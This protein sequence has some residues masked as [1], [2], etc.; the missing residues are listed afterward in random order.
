[1]ADKSGIFDNSAAATQRLITSGF[2]TQVFSKATT[3]GDP[4]YSLDTNDTNDYFHLQ[5]TQRSSLILTLNGLTGNADL[6][7]LDNDGNSMQGSSNGSALAESIISGS[8]L[9]AGDYYIRVY[10]SNGSTVV[11]QYTLSVSTLSTSRTDLLWRN[12]STGQN[13]IWLMNGTSIGTSAATTSVRDSNWKLEATGDMDGDTA[14]D[15]I[16]RNYATGQNAIWLMDGTTYRSA[17]SFTSVTNT[18]FKIVGATDFDGDGKTDIVWRNNATG[19]NLIWLMNGLTYRTAVSLQDF[20]NANYRIDA[21]GD[22]NQDGKV[23]LLW[24]NYSTGQNALWVMNG[25]SL[26]YSVSLPTLATSW[27]LAGAADLTNDGKL[28]LIWRKESGGTNASVVWQM[29]GV[30]YVTASFITNVSDANWKIATAA[31][32]P[33]NVDLAGN[34]LGTAFDIG[35]LNATGDYGDQIGGSADRNDYYKFKLQAASTLNMTLT[36]LT[37]NADVWLIWD[38]NNNG[39]YDASD[40]K[41]DSLN[42]GTADEQFQNQN[43]AAGTYFL[44][45][46]TPNSETLTTP[47]RLSLG[48]AV[49]Q[50]IDL[51]PDST[52]NIKRIGGANL[53]GTTT[54]SISLKT[55]TSSYVPS[56]QINYQ[57]K[58]NSATFTPSQF[59]VNFYL[60]R[61]NVIS[62]TNDLLLSQVDN[63]SNVLGDAIVAINNLAVG[64]TYSSSINVAVP[65]QDASFWGGD[66]TYYIGMLIDSDN[67]VAESIEVNNTVVTALGIKDTIRPDVIGGGLNIS[68]T[69]AAPSQSIQLSGTIKNIGNVATSTDSNAKF[70]V[71]FYFSNDDI[72]DGSD[73]PFAGV[74]SV[75]TIAANSFRDFNSNN[76]VTGSTFSVTPLVLPDVS[77]DGWRGNG[78]YYVV[79][80]LNVLGG[81]LESSGGIENNSNYGRVIGQYIDYDYIDIINAPNNQV[82]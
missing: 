65:A 21:V 60:S 15:Y 16:W 6:E 38:T 12:Y 13:A 14:P 39:L 59:K 76:T 54:P 23:D 66:Q 36:G 68:Q 37:A 61:D 78:R 27:S 77:W 56:I 22:F 32:T 5:L 62:S 51:L 71:R 24:R 34:S 20:T 49:G 2:T 53:P 80:E 10:T 31:M 50:P 74:L 35:T 29:N 28:D 25:S 18:N 42:L 8:P 40:V 17:T 44:R 43:L 4:G 46:F 45:I 1:M 67:Q 26:S 47:Y 3:G 82:L 70:F 72:Y 41:Y 79:M 11:D 30:S 64:Q 48:A 58:N 57:V 81:V 19:Q 9:E 75:Q 33:A 63:N 52:F 55:G 73:A 69:S 7:L